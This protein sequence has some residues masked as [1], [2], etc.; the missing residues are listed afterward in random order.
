MKWLY[1]LSRKVVVPIGFNALGAIEL[2][3]WVAP[4]VL[5]PQHLGAKWFPLLQ[6]L[7]SLLVVGGDLAWR[8]T[9]RERPLWSQAISPFAGGTIFFVPGWVV[10]SACCALQIFSELFH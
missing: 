10:G 5:W 8:R 2:T 4:T 6:L 7:F 9:E 1:L 3:F